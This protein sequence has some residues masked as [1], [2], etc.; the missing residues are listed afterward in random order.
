MPLIQQISYEEYAKEKELPKGEQLKRFMYRRRFLAM[1]AG[2]AVSTIVGGAW[3]M[4]GDFSR[5]FPPEP[6]AP[7]RRHEHPDPWP[8]NVK[9]YAAV[10]QND[11]SAT[12]GGLLGRKGG[13]F[14]PRLMSNLREYQ[15]LDRAFEA[16]KPGYSP[17]LTKRFKPVCSPEGPLIFDKRE[18]GK[19]RMALLVIG[20]G[21]NDDGEDFS[22]D[23][24]ADID[25][26]KQTLKETFGLTTVEDAKNRNNDVQLMVLDKPSIEKFQDALDRIKAQAPDELLIYLAGEGAA[27]EDSKVDKSL[28]EKEGGKKGGFDICNN[29]SI[30]EE[31]CKALL[32]N[33]F[34]KRCVDGKTKQTR[35]ALV[36]DSC[37]AGAFTQ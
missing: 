36:F 12:W 32:R 3:M 18:P 17:F 28:Q 26:V 19:H 14:T 13:V 4:G 15:S 7:L 24:R 33:R 29:Q 8:D 5:V 10:S 22:A 27:I 21:I 2:G 35:I 31:D 25:V 30:F 11:V 37:G 16:M 34:Q 20:G 23:I 6:P 1:L 9:I